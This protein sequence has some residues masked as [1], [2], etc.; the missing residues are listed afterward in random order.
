MS[1]MPA[2]N[3]LGEHSPGRL[4]ERH[5]I[6][7]VHTIVGWAP[8]HA[9]HFSTHTDGRIDQSRDTRYQSAA[10][11]YG[12]HRVIAIENEDGGRD[13]PLSD[14]QVEAC[15]Q[16][17][18]W[19][20]LEHGVPLQLCPDSRPGS[21][22]LAYHRQGIDGNFDPP[23]YRY[24][25]RVSGGEVWTESYGKECPRDTRIAQLPAILARAKQIVN[26]DE[27]DMALDKD[28]LDKIADAVWR[29][30]IG[31]G[32]NKRGAALHLLWA[33][34]ASRKALIQIRDAAKQL[35]AIA[36]DVKDDAT[37]AQLRKVSARLTAALTETE[38]S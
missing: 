26:G 24:P 4:M 18:A 9:A 11:L 7:C 32:D 10:N 14:G 33:S 27:D 15:A 20:H 3:W 23:T 8:A 37:K 12:N 2:A 19:A 34:G 25:G 13:V 35:D 36:A 38:E 29:R 6:V 30:E 28:A 16:I 21:R 5:D 22:G 31:G 1:R 17:L